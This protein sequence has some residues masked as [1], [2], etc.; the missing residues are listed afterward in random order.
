MTEQIEM[1]KT[2]FSKRRNEDIKKRFL[3]EMQIYLLQKELF[4]LSQ[5]RIIYKYM[6]FEIH[7]KKLISVA[8]GVPENGLYNW[9]KLIS[10]FKSKN[11]DLKK[12]NNY[13][14]VHNILELNN[15]IK[16]S[17][18]LLNDRTKNIPEFQN[19]KSVN[20]RL[21]NEFYERTTDSP[22]EFI[23][24]IT[25]KIQ[26]DLY[27]FSNER[28]ESMAKELDKRMDKVT[29]EKFIEKLKNN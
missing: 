4:A 23:W 25:K 22:K 28:I 20:V 19:R 9:D 15:S 10:F 6:Q 1:E 7:L 12:L 29:K 18:E 26:K 11:I 8:Y 13:S 2:E 16:H 17:E 5:M 3:T 21:I 14:D 27:D 24:E